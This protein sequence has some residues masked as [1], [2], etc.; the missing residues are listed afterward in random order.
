MALAAAAAISLGCLV[1][2]HLA[3]GGDPVALVGTAALA[4]TVCVL[5]WIRLSR[6]RVTVTQEH[7]SMTGVLRTRCHP[8]ARA[9]Q[10]VRARLVKKGRPYP[11]LFVLDAHGRVLLRVNGQNVGAYVPY[12]LDRLAHQLALP[13]TSLPGPLTGHQ[14]AAAHPHLATATERRP[15]VTA[16][17]VLL[18]VVV[19]FLVGLL[20]PMG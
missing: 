2:V 4:V 9:A 1:L 19:F 12:D 20:L 17:L 11:V 7:L 10:V 3:T 16:L 15:V 14:L 13:Q 18:G 6:L 5:L 8:R